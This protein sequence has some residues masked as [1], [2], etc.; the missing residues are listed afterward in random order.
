MNNKDIILCISP[1]WMGGGCGVLRVQQNVNYINQNHQHFGVKIIMTPVPIFDQNILNI[2]RC[3]FVQRPFQPMPWLKEYKN[4][5]SKFGFSIVGEV[6]DNFTTYKGENIPDYNM[7]S[8]TPRDWTQIDKIAAENLQ[9]I[10]RMITAT[11]YLG[12]ILKEKFNFWNTITIP[13]VCERALWSRERKDFFREKPLVLSASAMQHVRP[14][15][16]MSQQFP[17][18]VSG[19]RGDYEGKWPEFLIKN[20]DR[21]DLHYFADIPYF[22][23]P[24]KEKIT[25]HPWQSTDLYIGEYNRIRP[26]IVIAPLKN[27]IFNRCKSRLKFTECCASGAILM[28]TDFEDSP[29]NCIH[30]LCKVKDKPTVEELEKVFNNIKNTGRRLSSFSTNLLTRTGNGLNLKTT[31]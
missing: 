4:L 27:N 3:I 2:T 19:L 18:G 24:I 1:E 7:S 21:M 9:Y 17:A 15:Q 6:D 14:P 20:I 16:P 25:M 5:Q 22:L 26:D 8:L 10:D 30:P 13:N 31:F 23:D 29:Y 11:D 28:G 12:K